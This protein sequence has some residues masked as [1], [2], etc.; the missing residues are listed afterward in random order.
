MPTD[1]LLVEFPSPCARYALT[2]ED[3]G[4]VAYAYLKCDGKIVGDIWLYNRCPTPEV[5]EWTNRNNFPFANF[6]PYTNEEGRIQ[7]EVKA[8]DV[9]VDWE[10][11]NGE[12][13][14][15]VYV[16]EELFGSVGLHEKPGYARLAT[17]DGPLARVMVL[18]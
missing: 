6:K 2:F 18:G 10:Y 17:R 11:Q 1:A 14:A 13:V 8:R 16:F 5:A 12:P 4:K 7:R 9:N 15:F 3:N